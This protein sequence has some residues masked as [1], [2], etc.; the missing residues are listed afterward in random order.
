MKKLFAIASIFTLSF[1]LAA[2]NNEAPEKVDGTYND[3]KFFV[4][5]DTNCEYVVINVKGKGGNAV[6]PRMTSDGTHMCGQP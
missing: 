2:C 6:T 4:D 3:V 1:G 5:P